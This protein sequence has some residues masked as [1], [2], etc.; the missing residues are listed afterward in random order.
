MCEGAPPMKTRI[1]WILL[2]AL[3]ASPT[4]S[5][6]E[7]GANA[8]SLG[9]SDAVRSTAVGTTALYF[10]PAAMHQF[11]QYAVETGYQF[12]SPYDGHVFSVGVVDSATNEMLAAGFSYSY[13]M[14]HELGNDIERTGHM[15]RGGLAS[16]YRS[17]SISAHAGVGIRYLDL[18]VGDEGTADGLTLDA[19]ALIVLSNMFRLAV[20]GHNLIQTDLSETPRQLGLGASVLWYSLLISFDAVLDFET[21]ETTEVQYNGG[22]E[23]AIGGQIPLRLGYQYDRLTDRQQVSGGIGYVSSVLA[24]DFGFSQSLHDETDNIFSLNTRVFIP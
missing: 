11:R 10:N 23:Y 24:I 19:G 12:V 15:I 14:G 16:G 6:R 13:L 17:Q 1:S 5:A 20:V 3:L 22:L 9:V 7:E 18:T 21:R 2:F 8:T 4:A